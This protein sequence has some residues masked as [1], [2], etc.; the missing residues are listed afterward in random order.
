MFDAASWYGDG[1]WSYERTDKHYALHGSG[2]WGPWQT[3]ID[4]TGGWFGLRC[5]PRVLPGRG[6]WDGQG[7]G[8]RPHYWKGG[9]G[10]QYRVWLG[11]A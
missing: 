2:C 9:D 5:L 3:A 7:D 4:G 10:Y 1:R 11:K 8:F 6:W